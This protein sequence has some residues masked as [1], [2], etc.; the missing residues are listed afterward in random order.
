MRIET[1]KPFERW[2]K[3]LRDHAAKARITARLLQVQER[4]VLTGDLKP[5]GDK[6]VEMRFD[7]GPGYRVYLTQEGDQVV[8]LLIGGDKSSQD[9]DIEKAK[10]LAK[11]WRQANER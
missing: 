7:F 1:M 8:V 3:K 6:V 10:K 9:A 11:E 5:V 4:G 2:M